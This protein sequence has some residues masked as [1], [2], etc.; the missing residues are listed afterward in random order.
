MTWIGDSEKYGLVGLSVKIEGYI[1]TGPIAPN[2]WVLADA[3]F[4]M[5]LHWREWLGTI[6]ADQV[7]DFDLFLVSK[8]H[9]KR[10]HGGTSF[11]NA[12]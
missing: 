6:R 11:L 7:E 1:P 8:A 2:L 9:C 5:P 12:S 10:W 3:G 4:N